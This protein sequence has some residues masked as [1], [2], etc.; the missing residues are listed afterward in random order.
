MLRLKMFGLKKITKELRV[1]NQTL[2]E[3]KTMAFDL[4]KLLDQ[5]KNI[6]AAGQ[7]QDQ[8]VALINEHLA[9]L[10]AQQTADEAELG[11]VETGL[12]AVVDKLSP[13]DEGT[14]PVDTGTASS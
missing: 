8:I 14:A 7:T 13:S 6:V 2:K 5:V 1:L 4:Q 12:Q 10:Q 9:P 3:I 11:Q